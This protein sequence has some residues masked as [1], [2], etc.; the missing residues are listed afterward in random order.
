[1]HCVIKNLHNVKKSF[2]K[3]NSIT[4]QFATKEKLN[5]FFFESH[6]INYIYK[7]LLFY[8][9]TLKY[10][11]HFEMSSKNFNLKDKT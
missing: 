5:F 8:V 1:M 7:G 10:M 3:C 2:Y 4:T 11:C 9:L 6:V